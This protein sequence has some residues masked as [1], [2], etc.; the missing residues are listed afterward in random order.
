M[1]SAPNS[2]RLIR[3]RDDGQYT[4]I[5]LRV[6]DMQRGKKP[7]IQLQANDVVYIPFSYLRNAMS[8]GTSGIL[9]AAATA[10]VY[11]R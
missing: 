2:A 6:A 5:N 8:L 3:K 7:D 11:L 1:S 10:A 9:S 4:V